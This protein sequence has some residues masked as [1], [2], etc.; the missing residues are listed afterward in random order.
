[1]RF[2]SRFAI[3]FLRAGF[4]LALLVATGLSL[5]PAPDIPESI[6]FWDKGQH[7]AEYFGL[8]LIGGAAYFHHRLRVALGLLLHGGLIELAQATLTS[9]RFGDAYDWLA[10]GLGIVLGLLLIATAS[11]W[12]SFSADRFRR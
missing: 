10:D 9:T 2:S 11:R 6:Q 8:S 5:L 12:L 7:I 4:F 1:M 3:L